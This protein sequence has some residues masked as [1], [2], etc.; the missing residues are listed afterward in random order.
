MEADWSQLS[1]VCIWQIDLKLKKK[2]KIKEED[3]SATL[4]QQFRIFTDYFSVQSLFVWNEFHE[5][6]LFI[7]LVQLEFQ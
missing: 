3:L 2:E 5:K 7:F 6:K 4:S 1:A